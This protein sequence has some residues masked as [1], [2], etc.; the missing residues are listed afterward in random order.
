MGHN[1]VTRENGLAKTDDFSDHF[2]KVGKMI[3]MAKNIFI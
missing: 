2:A 3:T 1:F